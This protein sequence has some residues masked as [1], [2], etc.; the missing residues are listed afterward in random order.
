VPSTRKIQDLTPVDWYFDFVSPFSYLAL[1]RLAEIPAAI[2]ARPVLFAGL[3]KHWG[4]V[5]PAEIP[6]KRRWTYRWCQW[7][8]GELG[9]AFRFPAA[10]P[11][12]P[13]P[14]LRLALAC[15]SRLEPIRRIF[16]SIWTSGADAGDPARF[17]ALCREVD[18][19]EARLAETRDLLRKNTEEAAALGVFGVPSFV[20]DKEVFWGADAIDFLKAFLADP[21]V[22]RNPEMRRLDSLPVGAARNR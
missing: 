9:I 3:L 19:D 5:G 10:H 20:A 7:W 15:G 11:F 6:A 18:V 12:N 17:S 4:H 13:L 16:D 2:R 21:T 1:H 22:V 8:A 14:H